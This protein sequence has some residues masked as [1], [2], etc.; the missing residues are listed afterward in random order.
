MRDSATASKRKRKSAIEQLRSKRGLQREWEGMA[1]EPNPGSDAPAPDPAMMEQLMKA[2]GGGGGSGGGEGGG[3]GMDMAALQAMLGG[4]GGGGGGLGGG[5]EAEMR[6]QAQANQAAQAEKNSGEADGGADGK[7]YKWE[8][9]S[10]VCATSPTDG[11]VAPPS[12]PP[13]TPF[14]VPS[15]VRRERD[16]CPLPAQDAGHE[17]GRQ[18]HLQG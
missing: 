12:P 8:Q 13:L 10:K 2:M 1:E 18:G 4:L 16:H 3:G 11:E 9:T 14:I 17:E 15:A 6:R 5:P 7:A